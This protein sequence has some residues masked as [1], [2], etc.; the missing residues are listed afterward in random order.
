MSSAP[1]LAYERD[2]QLLH[3][4]RLV[5]PVFGDRLVN[6]FE[7]GTRCTGSDV[8]DPVIRG[9]SFTAPC[10]PIFADTDAYGA[11][12]GSL[13]RDNCHRYL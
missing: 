2:F 9:G 7:A 12:T 11:L 5:K 1:K 8:L 3:L 10:D 4:G 6:E 13:A